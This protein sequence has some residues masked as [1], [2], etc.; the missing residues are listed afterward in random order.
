[1]RVIKNLSIEIPGTN[2][3][4][5]GLDE[6]SQDD[7]QQVL[8]YGYTNLENDYE[9]NKIKNYKRKIYLNVT[10]PTEFCSSQSTYA[11]D[12]FD[13]IYGIC[14]LTVKWLNEIKNVSKYKSIFY[15][16]NEKDIPNTQLKLYDVCY[17]GGI[18]GS[19]YT[20]CLEIMSNFNYRY[21]TMTHG[22]NDLTTKN[23]HRATN[24]NLT[25]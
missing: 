20:E 17:H 16:F 5:F 23:L 8:L 10:M 1:M 21:M 3:H 9:F 12:K 2:T 6:F 7:R 13:E 14:P 11:D 15:P 19:L 22:I 24:L 25:N 18:H 4:Y